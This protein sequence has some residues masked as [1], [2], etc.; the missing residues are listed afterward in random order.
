MRDGEELWQENERLKGRSQIRMIII[1]NK[2]GEK[3]N[4]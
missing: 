3:D 4:L 2:D 1:K